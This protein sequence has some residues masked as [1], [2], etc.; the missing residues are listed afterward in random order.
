MAIPANTIIATKYGKLQPVAEAPKAQGERRSFICKCDCGNTK[1]VKLASLRNGDTTSCGCVHKAQL[2]KRNEKHGMCGTPIHRIW[3]GMKQRCLNKNAER[4][5][6]YGG[7]GITIH[8]EWMNDFTAFM[9]YI[10]SA[11]GERPEGYTLDRIDNDKGYEPN[12]L[13][14]ATYSEQNFNRREFKKV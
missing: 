11:I 12:N 14:W 8:K 6:D 7:R 5:A 2:A 4:Y 3:K 10:V 13:R 1:A 9:N